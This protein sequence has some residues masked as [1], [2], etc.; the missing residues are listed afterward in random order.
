MATASNK[1]TQPV[2]F[3]LSAEDLQKLQTVQGA[4][5][6]IKGFVRDGKLMITGIQHEFKSPFMH[7]WPPT[8]DED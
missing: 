8:P 7:N 2:E 5:T 3:A 6:A 1:D 4:T